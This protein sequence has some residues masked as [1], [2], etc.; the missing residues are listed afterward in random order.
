MADLPPGAMATKNEIQSPNS[1]AHSTDCTSEARVLP[2]QTSPRLARMMSAGSGSKEEALLR[3]VADGASPIPPG[4]CQKGSSPGGTTF[5]VAC[6]VFLPAPPGCQPALP[7]RLQ[8][9]KMPVSRKAA[10]HHRHFATPFL[11]GVGEGRGT[12]QGVSP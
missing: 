5:P 10:R 7:V 2:R 6:R 4:V 8:R 9:V 3:H 12:A 1:T 11:L